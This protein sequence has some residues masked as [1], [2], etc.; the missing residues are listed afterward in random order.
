CSPC[1][2]AAS[3]PISLW[4]TVQPS[5]FFVFDDEHQQLEFNTPSHVEADLINN[6]RTKYAPTA[7]GA[8]SHA[9]AQLFDRPAQHARTQVRCIWPIV[10]FSVLDCVCS[11]KFKFDGYFKGD[12]KQEDVFDAVAK[13]AVDSVLE[14]YNATIFAYGQTGSGKTF[15]ITGGAERCVHLVQRPV[16]VLWRMRG[17]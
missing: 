12:C 17:M 6:T 16:F 9:H 8:P 7:I 1:T 4:H 14:G 5:G 11:Y 15:T 13:D 2:V 10:F 3:L